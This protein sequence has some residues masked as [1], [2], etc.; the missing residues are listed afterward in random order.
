M[1]LFSRRSRSSDDEGQPRPAP[2]D[3]RVPRHVDAALTM[4]TEADAATFRAT[5]RETLA[6]MGYEVVVRTD[7]V[8]TD[9][10][11]QWGLWN[12][13]AGCAGTDPQDWSSTI[14]E[15]FTTIMA[16]GDDEPLTAAYLEQ[17]VV[18]R[19]MEE[20]G[21]RQTPD[22]IDRGL[23]WAPGVRQVVVVDTPQTVQVVP[24]AALEE[25]APLG[26][27]FDR[28]LVNLRAQLDLEEFELEEIT[29]QDA[30]FSCL[31]GD[32]VYTASLA[33]LLPEV[34]RRY[35]ARP[36]SEKGVLF[37]IPYRHQLAFHVIDEP[38]AAL[39]ALM[40]LPQFAAAGFLEGS[41]PVSPS[42]FWW[43]EGQV[44]QV[45]TL[46]AERTLSVTPGPEL[47][48]LLGMTRPDED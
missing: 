47:E 8:T 20:D 46:S 2:G 24:P 5:V 38:R 6:E 1:G 45:S 25:F 10:D 22:W 19:L 15:H 44:R 33:L 48:A 3:Q 43:H 26:P 29:H 11:R 16:T 14:R 27:W 13:A 7:H 36:A 34:V 28:G 32:S 17:H 31:L 30:S 18:A 9:D 40:V 39:E 42:V 21:L 37:A 23:E 41:G 12:L 4:F 35:V